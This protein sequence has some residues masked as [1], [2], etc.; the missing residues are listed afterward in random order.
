MEAQKENTVRPLSAVKS[1]TIFDPETMFDGNSTEEE[2][3]D[4]QT[5][6]PIPGLD[7]EQ[8]NEIYRP[9]R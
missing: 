5:Q 3:N 1:K 8:I 4:N 9:I 7:V 6:N 2:I